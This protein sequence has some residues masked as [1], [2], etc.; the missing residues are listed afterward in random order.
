VRPHELPLATSTPHQALPQRE[1][2]S[3]RLRCSDHQR[4][5][6]SAGVTAAIAMPATQNAV[7]IPT[8]H[9]YLTTV[10]MTDLAHMEG[11]R[12][13]SS[14]VVI[15]IGLIFSLLGLPAALLALAFGLGLL[16]LPYQLFLVL[17]RLP[18]AFPLH[19]IAS[20][21]ALILIPIAAF[22]RHHR[23][24][25]RAAGRLAAACVTIGGLTALFVALASEASAAARAGFFLQGLIWLALLA[26]AVAAIRCGDRALHARLMI[27]MAC[28]AS[29]ALWLRLVMVGAVV[30]NLPFETVYAVAA[31]VC[32]L[33]PLAIA[34]PWQRQQPRRRGRAGH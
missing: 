24:V 6:N 5:T 4:P 9:E 26:T 29:G 28:V 16:P 30:L 19:M 32:W 7:I 31:W 11:R 1:M 33:I 8:A 21:F 2:S 13:P 25:H 14:S 27:A 20:G 12:P 34:W 3:V 17:Q 15:L 22:T 10:T 18:I 23:E